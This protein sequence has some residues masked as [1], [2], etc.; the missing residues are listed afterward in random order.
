M[1]IL[2]ECICQIWVKF[3]PPISQSEILSILNLESY[4][5]KY[6]KQCK[7]TKN[8]CIVMYV[9]IEVTFLP[10]FGQSIS[11]CLVVA[12]VYHVCA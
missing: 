6:V 7:I 11:Y 1:M 3:E 10:V 8:T 2:G 4:P 12:H 5:Q 9:N